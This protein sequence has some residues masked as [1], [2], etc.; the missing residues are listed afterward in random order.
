MNDKKPFLDL[1]GFL[2]VTNN[3]AFE[4]NFLVVNQIF[5]LPVFLLILCR[6]S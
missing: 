1:N 3:F 4:L 2:G 6:I 5:S